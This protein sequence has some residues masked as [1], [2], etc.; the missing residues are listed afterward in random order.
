MMIIVELAAEGRG[1]HWQQLRQG[2]ARADVQI[3]IY[4][5][6]QEAIA[7]IDKASAHVNCDGQVIVEL[8]SRDAMLFARREE[9]RDDRRQGGHRLLSNL[10]N[11]PIELE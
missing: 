11:Y 7:P 8:L 4:M 3:L 1:E 9:L 6:G 2:S 10:T 5:S